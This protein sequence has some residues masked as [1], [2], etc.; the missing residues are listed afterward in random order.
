MLQGCKCWPWMRAPSV[1]VC[2]WG[3]TASCRHAASAWGR[4]GAIIALG[5]TGPLHMHRLA[6]CLYCVRC[7]ARCHPCLD[8]CYMQVPNG[9]ACQDSAHCLHRQALGLMR[10]VA[11][12]PSSTEYPSQI[13]VTFP[14]CWPGPVER[15]W[16]ELAGVDL[17]K[18]RRFM[19]CPFLGDLSILVPL[20]C[21]A[22]MPAMGSQSEAQACTA[23]AWH[24]YP[25]CSQLHC[26][27]ACPVQPKQ[28]TGIP[29]LP[30]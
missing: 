11:K 10:G 28:G 12:T 26:L 14:L 25:A 3:G 20:S 4:H 6:V 22:C 1:F 30:T 19:L 23:G 15:A 17:L 9:F 8:K 7:A 29:R 18:Q 16:M 21:T 24:R 5:P 27:R 2:L 13:P